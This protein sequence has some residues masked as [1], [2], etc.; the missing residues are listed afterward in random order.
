MEYNDIRHKIRSG[1]IIAFSHGSW[2]SWSS[3]KTNLV[4]IFT[5]ST[6]SHV[7]VAWLA[8]NRIFI[9]E[10]VKPKIRIFPLSLLGDFYLIS[11]NATWLPETEEYALSN[12]GVKYSELQA[13][14]AFF[15]PLKSGSIQ[16]CAAYVREVM[17]KDGMD[18]GN[19]SRPDH[20]VLTALEK[21]HCNMV[22]VNNEINVE[23][24]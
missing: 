16:E 5:R 1:D 9:L 19:M 24:E 2:K 11:T 4:R 3:I 14:E 22:Y 15:N 17:L 7:G 18:L 21:Y 6:Y 20:I 8:A 23:I 13:V 12:I 10:A